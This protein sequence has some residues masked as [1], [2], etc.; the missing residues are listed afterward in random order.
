MG[1]TAPKQCVLASAS[2]ELHTQFL[3]SPVVRQMALG[4]DLVPLHEPDPGP[5]PPMLLL[6]VGNTRQLRTALFSGASPSTATLTLDEQR[7]L[8]KLD[9][10]KLVSCAVSRNTIPTTTRHRRD[11]LYLLSATA[12]AFAAAPRSSVAW[13]SSSSRIAPVLHTVGGPYNCA[14]HN[15]STGHTPPGPRTAVLHTRLGPSA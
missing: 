12:W 5:L 13:E 15:V 9:T 4:V 6:L 10:P 1:H 7:W 14:G 8:F 3:P 2:L 11:E